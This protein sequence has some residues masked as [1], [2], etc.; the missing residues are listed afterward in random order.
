MT[1]AKITRQKANSRRNSK[2]LW[3]LA[4]ARRILNLKRKGQKLLLPD[5]TLRKLAAAGLPPSVAA[6][7]AMLE[8]LQHAT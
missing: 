2:R 6:Y 7:N 5:A 8:E 1:M 4:R 3:A